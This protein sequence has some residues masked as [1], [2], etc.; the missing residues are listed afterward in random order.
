MKKK[1]LTAQRMTFIAVFA[2]LICVCSWIAI[3]NPL[4]AGVP[5]TL[6]TFAI[7]LAGL[8]LTPAE[9]GLVSLVYILLGVVGLPIFSGF[10]TLYTNLFSPTGGYII[11][12]FIAPFLIS[13][14]LSFFKRII[15]NSSTNSAK[16]KVILFV[17]RI[18]IAIVLGILIID[19]PGVIVLKIVTGMDFGAAIIAGAVSFLPTDIFKCVLA[20]IIAG[21]L[22]IPLSKLR[23]C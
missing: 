13:L 16:Q 8:M 9:A 23:A 4:A 22:D 5:F 3:P 7:I 21:A 6:Q 17:T 15:S 14:C 11:G 20:A 1:F 12:F 2:A 10:R 18:V 19:I